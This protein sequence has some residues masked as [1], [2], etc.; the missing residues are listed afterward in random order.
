MTRVINFEGRKINVPDDASDAE[1]S[2]IISATVP[3]AA[4][5]A[6]SF[7]DR[8][9][10]NPLVRGV[11]GIA[12]AGANLVTGMGSSA[13]GGINGLN[14]LL[15]GGSLDDAT[16]RIQ[17]TQQ[18][19]TYQPRTAEGVT[20]AHIAAA[21]LELA[22]NV[23]KYVGGNAGEALGN[24]DAGEAIGESTPAVLATLLGGRAALKAAPQPTVT[25][26]SDPYIQAKLLREAGNDSMRL[27]SI[28][29]A[30]DAGLTINPT[31]VQKTFTNKTAS[32]LVGDT[33]LNR[34]AFEKNSP[35]MNRMIKEDIGVPDG[36]PLSSDV[37]NARIN[38]AAAPYNEIRKVPKF[39]PDE[40][41]STDINAMNDLSSNSPAVQEFLKQNA[42]KLQEEVQKMAEDGFNGNDVVTLM[43]KFRKEANSTLSR[44]NSNNPPGV[45]DLAL[46]NAKSTAAKSNEG[47]VERNLTAMDETNPGQGYAD[48]ANRFR[49]GRATIAKIKTVEPFIDGN[50][51]FVPTKAFRMGKNNTAYTGNLRT[52]ADVSGS[53]PESF[54]QPGLSSGPMNVSHSGMVNT[55]RHVVSTPLRAGVLSDWYQQRNMSGLDPRDMRTRMGYTTQD[56]AAQL[57][58]KQP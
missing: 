9:T 17:E 39:T 2:Q 13:V 41:F 36:A 46:A 1:V 19:Y 55:A 12:E 49:E 40:Q 37:L 7:L 30:K 16:K 32:A 54:V 44:V 28:A 38:E 45:E 48:L 56:I 21:P 43:Q 5:S 8:L 26:A 24:R 15:G 6:P 57:R 51:N 11:N 35:I 23:G 27:D 3:T 34:V 58:S 14:T 47:K 25:G 31:A 20:S 29:K 52:L 18:K 10:S 22:G 33:D 42:P 4:P 53:F 50:G